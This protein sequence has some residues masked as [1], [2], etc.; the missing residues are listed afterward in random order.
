MKYITTQQEM[1]DYLRE[2]FR[3]F[4]YG[5]YG[6][7]MRDPII[8]VGVLQGRQKS[9]YAPK[10]WGDSKGRLPEIMFDSSFLGAEATTM[11]SIAI[12]LL[13]CM[14]HQY[15]DENNIKDTSNGGTYHNK[16]FKKI[17]E[18]HGLK[19]LGIAKDGW[20]GLRDYSIADGSIVL[21]I[22][23]DFT[24]RFFVQRDAFTYHTDTNTRNHSIADTFLPSLV[25]L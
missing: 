17:A 11:E 23:E 7:K 16:R 5:L 8:N 12:E 1:V 22:C 21:N 24:S 3:A 15:C 6:G 18:K 13:H 4:N 19:S 14:V 25:H 20:G 2:L 10:V 9:R